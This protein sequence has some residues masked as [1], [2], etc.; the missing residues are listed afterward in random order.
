MRDLHSIAWFA[1]ALGGCQGFGSWSIPGHPPLE[2]TLDQ[3]AYGAF[4]GDGPVVVSGHVTDPSATVWVEGHE[5]HVGP[6]GRFRVEMPVDGPYRNIDVEAA[7]P[8]R[9]LRERRPVFRGVDPLASWPGGLTARVT[10]RGLAR[11][12]AQLGPMIDELDWAGA[13]EA[14]IPGLDVSHAPTEVLL[15]PAE[16]GVSTQLTL[17]GLELGMDLLGMEVVLGLDAL[18]LGA[19]GDPT[20]DESGVLGLALRD[21]VVSLGEPT[22]RA[23]ALDLLFLE[24]LVAAGSAWVA[25]AGAVAVDL[26]LQTVG[27]VPLGGPLEIDTD[28]LGTD[29]RVDIAELY[30]DRAGL[31]VGMGLELDDVQGDSGGALPAPSGFEGGP[32]TDL[33]LGMHEGVV[34]LFLAS[35]LLALLEQD[36]TLSG[37]LAEFLLMPLKGLPGG[38]AVPDALQWCVSAT[39]GPARVARIHT[40]GDAIAT[41]YM[42]DLLLSIGYTTVQADCAPWLHASLA[43]ELSLTVEDGTAIGFDLS[44]PDGTLLTYS[45]PGLWTE[46]EVISGLGGLLDALLSLLGGS[47]EID[48]ADLSGGL[49]TDTALPFSPAITGIDV[50]LDASGEPV[51]GGGAVGLSIW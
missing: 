28:L 38:T 31:V 45:S 36:L 41:V 44:I 35:D 29:I 40:E 13:V 19:V 22:I 26:F 47:L 14:A 43:A 32:N 20:I 30:G 23:G 16:A 17:G 5:V 11:L 21:P 1:L 48:L 51:E 37:F 8:R 2:L 42:P 10:E 24:Q 49:G 3:P 50:L 18:V 7:S 15:S 34:Q 12:G 33:V 39:P 6:K 4:L 25:G 9:R 46:D 27:T